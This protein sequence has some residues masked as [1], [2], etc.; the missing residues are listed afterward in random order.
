M[1]PPVCGAATDEFELVDAIFPSVADW[2][3]SMLG[4]LSCVAFAIEGSL[5]GSSLSVVGAL[6][7]QV[8]PDALVALL[9]SGAEVADLIVPLGFSFSEVPT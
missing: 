6:E 2:A 1:N 5:V 3:L 4:V 9:A 8:D 7:C